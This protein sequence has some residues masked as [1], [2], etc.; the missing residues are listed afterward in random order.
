MVK[1]KFSK[2]GGFY[3]VIFIFQI[4]LFIYA[5]QCLVEFVFIFYHVARPSTELW[6]KHV[7]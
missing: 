1:I 4:N 3:E 7:F 5:L 2:A 6:R